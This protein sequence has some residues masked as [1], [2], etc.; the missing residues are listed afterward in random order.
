MRVC[1][2]AFQF[3]PSVG[4]AQT[5]AEKQARYLLQLGHAVQVITL[6]HK[7]A[8][9]G[10]ETYF[11]VP[12]L[13]I[14]GLYGPKGILHVGRF[15]HIVIDLLL[16]LLLWRARHDYDLI[17]VLQIS[18]LAVV[19]TMIGK[20]THKPVIIGVQTIG[21]YEQSCETTAVEK[22]ALP[23]SSDDA[24]IVGQRHTILSDKIG[25][26]EHL[27]QT[28]WGGNHM[29]N[30]LRQSHAYYQILSSRSYMYLLH[31]GFSPERIV[32][33]PNG[34]DTQQFYPA[35]W[36]RKIVQGKD[37]VLLCVARLEYG[38]GIDV[39]LQAWAHMLAMPAEWRKDLHPRLLLAGEGRCRME[40][41]QLGVQLGIQES[42]QFLGTRYDIATCLREAW[43]FV[44]A[45]RWEG[46]HNALLEALACGL[47]CITT[48]VS[49]S[50]DIIEQGI[51][52]L[53][54]ESEQPEQL[55]YALRLMIGD[56]DL[57]HQLGEHGYET[58]LRYY[59]LSST[60]QG[61]IAF[62]RYLLTNDVTGQ[63]TAGYAQVY[64]EEWQR[65]E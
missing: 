59:Q 32:Y 49:G 51:N 36:Q 12:I 31:H 26:I 62:Y 42:V 38:K 46:M 61:C 41:E 53:L 29:L 45:A 43:G 1:V 54:V 22:A 58:I 5:Q 25:D 44:L 3:W 57:A 11:G 10:N 35:T 9:S 18:P 30:Y 23:T 27:A 47:P 52:G 15:G 33:L 20:L 37:R 16:F 7:K 8:W 28:F 19:A 4:G 24:K 63:S 64:P 39:L 60:I 17:H 2:I 48:R 14:G 34:V 56:S 21:P 50:E 13:R 6:R 40:L 55:A 65:Y